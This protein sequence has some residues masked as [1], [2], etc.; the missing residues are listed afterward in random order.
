MKV[1]CTNISKLEVDG[2]TPTNLKNVNLTIGKH[3]IVIDNSTFRYEQGSYQLYLIK[4]DWG[5]TL[6]YRSDQFMTL[7]EWREMK[8]NELGIK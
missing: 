6:R 1:V 3:Y 4:D 2:K 5:L 7:E 8:L